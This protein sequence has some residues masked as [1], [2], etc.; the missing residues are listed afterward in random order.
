MP[1]QAR[2]LT[3]LEVSKLG[4]GTHA[5]GGV[6]GLYI[7]KVDNSEAWTLNI[8]INGKRRGNPPEK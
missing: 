3:A 2:I 6:L 4:S 7:T 8:T 1:K 5:V